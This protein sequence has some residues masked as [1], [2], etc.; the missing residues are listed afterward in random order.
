MFLQQVQSIDPYHTIFVVQSLEHGSSKKADSLCKSVISLEPAGD[1][2][3]G[4][5][6]LTSNHVWGRDE[7]L[8][9]GCL[10]FTILTIVQFFVLCVNM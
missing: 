10:V 4:E 6:F 7:M 2:S 1:L 8:A 3:L 9:A 5:K